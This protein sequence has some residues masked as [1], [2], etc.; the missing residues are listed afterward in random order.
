MRTDLL[1][2]ALRAGPKFIYALPNFQNP[3]GVTL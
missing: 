2:E 3:T 1:E